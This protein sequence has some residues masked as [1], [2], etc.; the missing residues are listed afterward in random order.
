MTSQKRYLSLQTIPYDDRA[1]V[2]ALFLNLKKA[3]PELIKLLEDCNSV[4][5][6]EDAIYRFYHQSFKV[7]SIQAATLKI[8]AK[9]EELAP[10]RSLNECF[11]KIV[12]EGTGKAWKE[13]DNRH[14]LSAT[15]PML[16]AFFHARY[17][18]E[19]A[20]KYGRELKKPPQ[21]LPSGWAAFLYL[22]NLR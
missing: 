21:L 6:Y 13:E 19:M 7:Y 17:F 22:Y 5:V 12:H 11:L 20:V 4:W 1:E 16:E 18:L 15:R 2:K 14:W 9:L 8:A 3:L 10:E